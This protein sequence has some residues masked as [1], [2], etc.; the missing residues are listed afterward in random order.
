MHTKEERKKI[1]RQFCNDEIN[2][3]VYSNPWWLDAV[4]GPAN[5]DVLIYSEGSNTIASMPFYLTTRLGI[6]VI[7]MPPFTQSLGPYIKFP[8]KISMQDKLSLEK[9]IFSFFIKKLPKA[10][11]QFHNLHYSVTNWLPFYWKGYRQ[12]TKYTYV[13]DII[14]DIDKVFSNFSYAKKKN[15]R[16]AEKEVAVRFDLSASEFYEHHRHTLRGQNRKI[17]YSYHTFERLY[18]AAYSNDSGRIIYAI[19]ESSVIHSA[20]FCVWDRISGYDLISSIDNNYRSS[21]SSSL[22]IWEL[23]K[24]LGNRVKKFDF[25]GSMSEPVENSFRQ[26]GTTQHPYLRIYKIDNPI[27]KIAYSVLPY[28]TII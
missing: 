21:G 25:E 14:S 24:M 11:A 2:M 28:S 16:K 20:I 4:C 7:K 27:L 12:T 6:N 23:I 5:W 19:D 8:G 1:F 3:P 17:V 13:I 15:I 18:N 9:K 26:F 10:G 22:L